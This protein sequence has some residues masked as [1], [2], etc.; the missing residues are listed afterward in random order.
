M[1]IINILQQKNDIQIL[2]SNKNYL[3]FYDIGKLKKKNIIIQD[4]YKQLNVFHK[5]YTL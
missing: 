2:T 1:G 3:V 5:T 4:H